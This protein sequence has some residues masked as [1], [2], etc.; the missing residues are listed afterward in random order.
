MNKK[1]NIVKFNKFWKSGNFQLAGGEIE[2]FLKG[3]IEIDGIKATD[4]A[5]WQLEKLKELKTEKDVYG[6]VP[7]KTNRHYP[8]VVNLGVGD[9]KN[10]VYATLG[11]RQQINIHIG[12]IVNA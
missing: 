4:Q 11:F 10:K 2:K 5:K 9:T 7:F 6:T 12:N 8:C 3:E 1:M